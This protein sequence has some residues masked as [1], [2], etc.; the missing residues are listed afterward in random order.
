MEVTREERD[1]VLKKAGKKSA[2]YEQVM[3]VFDEATYK[4]LP[5]SMVVGMLQERLAAKDCN[6]GA[7]FDDLNCNLFPSEVVGLRLIM[8]AVKQHV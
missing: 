6:A 8:Q 2:Q 5:E 4:Y 7:I 3:G 1:K